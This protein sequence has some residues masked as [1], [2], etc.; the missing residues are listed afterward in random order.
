MRN[1]SK[2]DT[3]CSTTIGATICICTRRAESGSTLAATLRREPAHSDTLQ[4]YV[5]CLEGHHP[6]QMSPSEPSLDVYKLF[7]V[8]ERWYEIPG[9]ATGVS[10]NWR[11]KRPT[12]FSA[13]ACTYLDWNT[14]MFLSA[15]E[16]PKSGTTQ[17]TSDGSRKMFR[18]H[19]PIAKSPSS[20]VPGIA[21]SSIGDVPLRGSSMSPVHSL[22]TLT[23]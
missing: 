22:G 8:N 3:W 5:V 6:L 13:Q 1:A 17:C 10:P 18:E 23:R 20:L 19:I 4:W 14:L 12:P 2:D 21:L 11:V 7:L 15:L 16:E 9:G